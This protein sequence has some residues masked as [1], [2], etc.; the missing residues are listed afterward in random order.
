M[1]NSCILI[2]LLLISLLTG[3]SLHR[4]ASTTVTY[5]YTNESE[6]DIYIP[7]TIATWNKD[8]HIPPGSTVNITYNAYTFVGPFRRAQNIDIL[9]N[10]DIT[11]TYD[12]FDEDQLNNPLIS[13]NYEKIEV[14]TKRKRTYVYEMY[15]T[16][17]Q[18]QYESV[19]P[20]EPWIISSSV[21]DE[22]IDEFERYEEIW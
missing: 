1:K 11:V 15:Y 12:I 20:V 6:V 2:S 18:E 8:V 17:T 4:E 14:P 10:N 21:T 3:C 9:F 22:Q 7:A 19:K 13:N 5:Y 16:F